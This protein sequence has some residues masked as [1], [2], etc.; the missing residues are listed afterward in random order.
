MFMSNEPEGSRFMFPEPSTG[1]YGIKWPF[2]DA[3]VGS[4]VVVAISAF[5]WK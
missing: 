1:D 3:P 5:S 2:T 4:R